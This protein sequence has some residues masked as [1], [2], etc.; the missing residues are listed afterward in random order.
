M[1]VVSKDSLERIEMYKTRTTEASQMMQDRVDQITLSHELEQP[2]KL[3]K[4]LRQMM[5]REGQ[6]AFSSKRPRDLQEP[7]YQMMG[8]YGSYQLVGP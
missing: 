4:Q 6:G 5:E 2:T 3:I 7:Q 8:S 1:N